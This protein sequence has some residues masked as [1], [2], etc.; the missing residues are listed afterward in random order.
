MIALYSFARGRVTTRR[1]VSCML[2][3]ACGVELAAAD[4]RC[5]L[6]STGALH[7]QGVSPTEFL[8]GYTAAGFA[9]GVVSV[10]SSLLTRSVSEFSQKLHRRTSLHSQHVTCAL[11]PLP[12]QFLGWEHLVLCL[13]L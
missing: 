6:L 13:A 10:S 9:G 11:R 12:K 7:H 8:V 3:N 1:G 2:P 5:M 4:T